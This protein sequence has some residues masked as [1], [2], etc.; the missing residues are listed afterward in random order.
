MEVNEIYRREPY[1]VSSIL[2]AH[3]A[4]SLIRAYV[5]AWKWNSLWI[6]KRVKKRVACRSF[7][8]LAVKTSDHQW[9]S[10]W[11]WLDWH[12]LLLQWNWMQVETSVITVQQTLYAIYVG[13]HLI[14]K[15][16][17]NVV[18]MIHCKSCLIKFFWNRP[19]CYI[20]M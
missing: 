3:P 20:L 13:H 15:S 8:D 12:F 18:K 10:Q 2:L 6:K 16:H 5:M 1:G 14:W 4:L 19:T 7:K 11:L 9:K 17:R